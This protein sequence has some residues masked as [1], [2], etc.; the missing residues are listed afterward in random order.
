[1]KK[2]TPN[3]IVIKITP[4][5]SNINFGNDPIN[6]PTAAL[7]LNLYSFCKKYLCSIY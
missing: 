4:K 2:V 1:M 5:A 6:S 3:N 7:R